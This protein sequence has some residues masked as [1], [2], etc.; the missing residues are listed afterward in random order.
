MR[1]IFLIGEASVQVVIYDRLTRATLR[2]DISAADV[3]TDPDL[4][5]LQ[6]S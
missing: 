3:K 2:N 4:I 1:I 5:H 6:K